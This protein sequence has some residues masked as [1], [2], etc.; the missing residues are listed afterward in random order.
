METNIILCVLYITFSPYQRTS[1]KEITDLEFSGDK[2]VAASCCRQVLT[3][4]YFFHVPYCVWFHEHDSLVAIK[5]LLKA[6]SAHV[7]KSVPSGPK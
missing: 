5:H 1:T 4:M 3:M 6:C 7:L 2:Q